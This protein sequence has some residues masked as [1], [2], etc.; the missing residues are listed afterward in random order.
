[1]L[2]MFGFGKKIDHEYSNQELDYS[3]RSKESNGL[4]VSLDIDFS[5]K[6]TI[7][8]S[9]YKK[10]EQVSKEHLIDISKIFFRDQLNDSTI[11]NMTKVLREEITFGSQ[12]TWN[13][14]TFNRDWPDIEFKVSIKVD[15]EHFDT[16]SFREELKELQRDFVSF[17]EE[18]SD[19]ILSG[20]EELKKSA[21]SLYTSAPIEKSKMR[22]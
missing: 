21:S 16:D 18:N 17:I 4:H 7:G 11:E 6:I 22:R 8:F 1:M 3:E 5:P 20:L 12:H 15:Y 13:V 9:A 19:G 14:F 10:D 2:I